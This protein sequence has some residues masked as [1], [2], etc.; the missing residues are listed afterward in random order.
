MQQKTVNHKTKQSITIGIL[1]PPHAMDSQPGHADELNF[2]IIRSPCV[3]L[4]T[5]SDV[6]RKEAWT[7]LS[8]EMQEQM[9]REQSGRSPSIS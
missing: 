2:L 5:I 6:H 8:N 4:L 1:H 3:T 9:K 7:F